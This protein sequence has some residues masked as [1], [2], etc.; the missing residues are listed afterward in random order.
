MF[1]Y[2]YSL[3]QQLSMKDAIYIDNYFAILFGYC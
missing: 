1:L 2:I 3:T